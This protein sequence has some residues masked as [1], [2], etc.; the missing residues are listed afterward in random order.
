M[1]MEIMAS[2]RAII[3]FTAFNGVQAWLDKSIREKIPL[4]DIISV[5][6]LSNV[7]RVL[8]LAA[9]LLLVLLLRLLLRW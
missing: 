7:I 3:G 5:V 2:K 1:I 6:N 4:G 8:S 9:V